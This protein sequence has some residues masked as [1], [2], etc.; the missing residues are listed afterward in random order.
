MGHLMSLGHT[1]HRPA[2]SGRPTT[3]PRNR[4]LGRPRVAFARRR[5]PRAARSHI[6]RSLLLAR[7]GPGGGDAAARAGRHRA[8]C[9]RATRWP[10]ARSG[11]P[12]GPGSTCPRD[13]SVVGY[14]D[15]ALMNCTDPPLTTVRQ[16]I[17][18]MGRMVIELLRQP[19]GGLGVS[20]RR[21]PLRAG[22]GRPRVHRAPRPPRPAAPREPPTRDAARHRRAGR[23]R[24]AGSPPVRPGRRRQLRH[25]RVRRERTVSSCID[26]VES[27]RCAAEPARWRGSGRTPERI[28]ETRA[29][30]P[31][32]AVAIDGASGG[33][34]QAPT[35]GWWRHA[36]I[37][38]VYPRSF[39]DANGDGTGDLA[40]VRGAAAATC[41]TSA[42]TPSGSRPGTSRRSRTAATTSP[43]TGPSTRSSASLEE[44]EGLIAEALAPG[45]PDHR[46]RRPQP[47]LGPA[48]LVPGGARGRAR[49]ARAGPVLVP[50]RSR[51]RRRRDAD[52]AGDPTSRA[53]PGPA[54]RTRT[55]RPASGTSTSS[56][57]QQPD[58][59]WD[60][61]D[62][63]AGARGHPPL[64]VRPRRRR[65]P[66][67]LGRAAGQGR[68]PARGARPIPAPGEHP[69]TDRDELHDIYRA[70]ARRS[71]TA[72]RATRILVG[73]VWLPDVERFA[74]YLRPDELHT[75]FN[76]DFMTRPWD[77][78]ALRA[79][80]DGRSPR[81]RRSARRPTWVLSNHDVTRPVTRYGRDDSSFA[82]AAKR[83][84]IAD[85]PRAR[86]PARPGRGPA[87]GGA[88]GRALHLPGRRA[89]PRRG[90]RP[91]ARP[92][93]GPDV[94]PLRR[95]RPRTRRLPRAA[96][97]VRRRRAVRLQ[98]GRRP[99]GRGCA[100]P[101][102]G[103]RLT[104][105]AQE[106]DPDS[107]L[108]L[109][110]AMLRS[111]RARARPRRRAAGLAA[112]ARTACSPSRGATSFVCVT[113]LSTR[114][115]LLP[116]WPAAAGQRRRS[117]TAA[118]RRTRRPGSAG[119]R[120][121]ERPLRDRGGG[122]C[123]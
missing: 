59:N 120:S 92:A 16:P 51:R 9:V 84:G 26:S 60:H 85:R 35:T 112:V 8:S 25:R 27:V 53:R 64:L 6:V 21:A 95:R 32:I 71:P 20:A 31:S 81:T 115:P 36:V 90:P 19:D 104:V 123:G 24:R 47:R 58:L 7:G 54:P 94:L 23:P 110:R 3:C 38:E 91:A 122:A 88:A 63:R 108:S 49:L 43:T 72:T 116:A 44:A 103:R 17:E 100:S 57:P 61:P 22:A 40:G 46:R 45:H 30:R 62:V 33:R 66:H 1:P 83:H 5:R 10:W 50:S 65:R 96:A 28:L 97:L 87:R 98:P 109:Y 73:E 34:R 106:A 80:I 118:C 76:F 52:R 67:R 121:S 41:A 56:R 113:N 69:N 107:M 105:E 13:V 99:A 119:R 37:Y 55:A 78:A 82:F 14:D 93:P 77:A 79:S 70:L 11:P 111:A 12:G 102:T 4:K 114:P 68:R 74:L 89:G 48:P 75:A 117:S 101:P 2:R 18:P 39:A 15:S 42:S 86:S 29:S